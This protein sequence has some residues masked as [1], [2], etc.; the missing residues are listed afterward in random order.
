[1][2]NLIELNEIAKVYIIGKTIEVPALSSVS[3]DIKKNEYVA[4]MGPSGSG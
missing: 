3:V 4:I 1:M 2:E